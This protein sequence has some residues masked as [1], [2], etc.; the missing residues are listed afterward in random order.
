MLHQGGALKKTIMVIVGLPGAGKSEVSSFYKEQGLPMF[1]TGDVFREEVVSRGLEL[2]PEN[3]EMIARR[4]REEQGR[5]V[6]ARITMEKILKLTDMLI[7]VEGPR[8]MDELAYI[9]KL[10][11]LILLVLKAGDN[12]RFRR[13][14]NRGK[15]GRDPGNKVKGFRNPKDRKE[16]DWRDG[17]EKERGL[18]E[19]LKTKKYP[20]YEIE[21]EG[22]IGELRVKAARV[23][24]AIRSSAR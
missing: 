4:L 16:F 14:L 7:C 12:T 3:S 22:T 18:A 15:S 6:A 13:Q 9:A 1:R 21:N 11:K 23:L 2:T 10:S 17:K 20:R 8:D 19:V 5:D 24:S